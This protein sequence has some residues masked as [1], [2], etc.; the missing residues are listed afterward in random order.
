MIKN[1]MARFKQEGLDYLRGQMNFYNKRD[2]RVETSLNLLERWECISGN[3][4]QR[5]IQI[6]E[7]PSGEFVDQSLFEKRLKNQN[8]KLLDL[9]QL[10]KSETCRMK[11]IYA[12]FGVTSTDCGHCDNC[13]G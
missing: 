11:T 5:E 10:A 12:Y 6:I 13:D 7:D 4:A 2:F 9:V 3:L 8:I 1:N